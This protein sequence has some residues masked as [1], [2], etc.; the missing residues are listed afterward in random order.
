MKRIHALIAALLLSAALTGCALD[1]SQESGEAPEHQ[2]T[3]EAPIPSEI[4][5]LT[6]QYDMQQ[7]EY[8]GC[9]V[10]EQDGTLL[11]PPEAAVDIFDADFLTDYAA[12]EY[13]AVFKAAEHTVPDVEEQYR[14]V[15]D[16]I[17]AGEHVLQSPEMRP[18][19]EDDYRDSYYIVLNGKTELLYS[20]GNNSGVYSVS[21]SEAIQEVTAWLR[22]AFKGR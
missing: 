12:G 17:A 14:I 7:H 18:E 10:L 3:T 11:W 21:S 16:A 2:E 19:V 9:A 8:I 6:S 4:L 20:S 5:F 22:E 1:A 13:D 15:A